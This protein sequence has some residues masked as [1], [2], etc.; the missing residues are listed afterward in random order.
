MASPTINAASQAGIAETNRSRIMR[1]LY[2]NGVSS[3]AQIATALGLTPAAITKITAQLIEAHAIEETGDLDGKKNRRSIGLA[4]DTAHFHVIGVKFARS[5]VQ[6]GVFDLTGN[7]SSLTTLPYVSN[8]TIGETIAT[9]HSTIEQLLHEDPTIVAIGMA[10][11]GPYLRNNGHTAV[12][13]SMQGWRAINFIDEFANSF[14][15]PVFIEQDARAGV[16]A[17]SLFDPNSNGEPNLAYYLVGEGVGLGVIDHGRIING[18]LG[19]ATEI[20]HV[21]IDVNGKPCDCGNIG[22]L[23]CYCSTPAIHQMLIDNG[24]IVNGADSM[25]H[26]EACRALFAL[27]HHGDEAALAMIR[28]IGTYIG[29]GCL[30]IFNTFNPHTIVIGD[31]VSEAGQPLLDEIKRTV[32][33][34][35]IPEIYESTTIRLTTMPTDATVLGAAAV[36]INYL[37]DHPSD[38][39]SFN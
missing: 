5:L 4:L 2:R 23:E 15:V 27:A 14:T 12:V 28:T 25:S 13:S 19:T 20:G 24:T 31:I 34:R 11:P 29:Y 37:L 16:L 22:C 30:I 7:Q 21:S 10:V 1:H 17:N 33:Q 36:A 26:T 3:R 9:V 35:A 32:R 38:F 6:I 8:D 18:A 39:F